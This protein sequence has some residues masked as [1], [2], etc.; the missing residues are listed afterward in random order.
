MALDFSTPPKSLCI[1]RLSAIGDVTNIVPV[2]RSI[3]NFWPQTAITWIVGKTEHTLVGDIPGIEFLIFD[4]T[5]GLSEYLRLHQQV[6]NRRYDVLLHMQASIRASFACLLIPSPIK[7]G[8]DI[9]RGKNLQW[10]FTNY[11]IPKTNRQHVLDG[12]FE[13]TKFLGI[14]DELINWDIPVPDDACKKADQWLGKNNFFIVINPSSSIRARNWRN[15]DATNYAR[16]TEYVANKYGATT[17]L[18]GGPS[19]AEKTF[20]ETIED[21]T[22]INV[23][24]LV[25]KTNLKE[26]MAVLQKASLVVSPDTG[27]AHIANAVNTPVIGLYASSNPERTGPYNYRHLTVNRYPEAIKREFGKDV[28]E[29]PW[30]KRVRNPD[31]M[32]LIFFD[33]VARNIDQVLGP[34]III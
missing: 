31:A 28:N 32:N 12:F 4:K 2:V 15:W 17:V 11:R 34:K 8:F 33:D 26:L 10:L 30:G 24:N 16:L 7:L 18:T 21:K 1:L 5:K 6:K 13:Y 9:S 20:A 25:G 23:L 19:A 22:N 3:Q 27:P 14:S 29:V